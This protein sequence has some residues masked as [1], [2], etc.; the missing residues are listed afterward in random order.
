MEATGQEERA[1]A[2]GVSMRGGRHKQARGAMF[3][4]VENLLH[5]YLDGALEEGLQLLRDLIAAVREEVLLVVNV[6]CCSRG[7][8]ARIA[9]PLAE[10]GVRTHVHS[11]GLDAADEELVRR[12]DEVPDTCQIVIIGS[13]DHRF[14]F[15]ARRLQAS[16]KQV[17]IVARPGSVARSLRRAAG[18]CRWFRTTRPDEAA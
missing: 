1:M 2:E 7:L 18:S 9:F 6:A 13:G 14:A 17:E 4:D 15:P 3:L 10:L 8:A 11:G 12:L 5:P 16:G